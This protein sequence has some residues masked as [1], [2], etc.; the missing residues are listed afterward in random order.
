MNQK[1]SKMSAKPQILADFG[2]IFGG[3]CHFS[4]LFSFPP[5]SKKKIAKNAK[6]AKGHPQCLEFLG[7]L[8]ERKLDIVSP[9][10]PPRP[11]CGLA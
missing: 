1:T 9:V 10:S 11:L 4:P 3:F 7:V 6:I 2:P 5:I 8:C